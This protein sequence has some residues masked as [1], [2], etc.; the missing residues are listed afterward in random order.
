MPVR[1]AAA[2][3]SLA[4]SFEGGVADGTCAS[5]GSAPAPPRCSGAAGS[6]PGSSSQ[7]CGRAWRGLSG[8][9]PQPARRGLL[10]VPGSDGRTSR[11]WH[12]PRAPCALCRP[13]RRV[14]SITGW[15][16]LKRSQSLTAPTPTTPS[17]STASPRE[18]WIPKASSSS[19]S[20]RHRDAEPAAVTAR[21]R[22]PPRRSTRMRISRT[23]TRCCRTAR[24]WATTTARWS[25]SGGRPEDARGHHG[26]HPR[27][28]T[29]ALLALQ[30]ISRGWSMR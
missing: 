5:L 18:R 13:C 6:H 1:R 27:L 28:W 9:P 29:S 21:T 19:T 26:R 7:L 10:I 11:P 15:E 17:C 3:P 12:V 4:A 8:V 25:W 16:F 2:T 24:A 20:C 23:S 30:I 22:S 14:T